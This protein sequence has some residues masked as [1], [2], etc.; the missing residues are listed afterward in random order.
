MSTWPVSRGARAHFLV[1]MGTLSAFGP[2][3]L[4]LYLPAFPQIASTM[5]VDTGSVQLTFSAALLGLS[6]GQLVYGPFADRFG[7][8]RPLLVGLVL[9][10]LASIAC[11]FAPSLPV[12]VGLRFL[13]AVG[14][15]SGIVIA[16]AII[17]DCYNG[18]DLAR[19]LSSVA[20]VMILAPIL[21]PSIGAFVLSVAS[22]PWV[23]I[24]LAVFGVA[25]FVGVLTI[26]E[27]IKDE[28]RTDHGVV[29]AIRAYGGILRNPLF[30]SAA[31]VAGSGQMMLFSYI[32]SAPAVFMGIYGLTQ[33]QFALL[34]GVNSFFLAVG[35]QINMRLVKRIPVSTLMPRTMTM[36]LAGAVGVLTATA[37]QLPLQFVW[38]PLAVAM[39]AHTAT[40]SNAIAE[41][42]K[43]FARSAGSAA[44]LAGVIGMGMASLLT[45]VLSLVHLNARVEM[46][47][48]MVFALSLGLAMAF[49]LRRLDRSME[50]APVA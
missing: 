24:V 5:G 7:R 12:L 22:W 11:A 16:R 33:T 15:C 27:T 39:L 38:A 46:G 42:L 43:P 29:G 47:F 31:L 18:A 3:S 13:Q 10:I 34:F 14:G 8:K 36:Q 19:A 49:R 30:V 9:F 26:P 21:A 4:D 6:L 37:L 41:A 32:S 44:A 50:A 28:H 48:G 35:A 45:T 17:R 23:F 1:V 20:T 40:T 2:M 25:A